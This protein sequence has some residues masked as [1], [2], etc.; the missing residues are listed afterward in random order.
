VSDREECKVNKKGSGYTQGGRE[1][2]R[3]SFIIRRGGVARSKV[4]GA[5]REDGILFPK[6]VGFVIDVFFFFK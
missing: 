3:G 2:E 4:K 6:S 5:P 1:I